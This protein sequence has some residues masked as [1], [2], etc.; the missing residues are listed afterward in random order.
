M[1]VYKQVENG[2]VVFEKYTSYGGGIIKYE[3]LFN[4]IISQS[5]C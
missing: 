4:E 1:R 5:S 2:N 3:N